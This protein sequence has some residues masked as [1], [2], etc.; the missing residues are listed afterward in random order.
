MSGAQEQRRE[1]AMPD[2]KEQFDAELA[3]YQA[4]LQ[5]LRAKLVASQTEGSEAESTELK[6]QIAEAERKISEVMEGTLYY[7]LVMKD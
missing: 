3:P 4:D 2:A 6:S 1:G 7:K 5:E